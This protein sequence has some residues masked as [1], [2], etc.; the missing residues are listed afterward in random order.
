MVILI[1]TKQRIM[2]NKVVLGS[3]RISCGRFALPY[4]PEP[5]S[6]ENPRKPSTHLHMGFKGFLENK[7]LENEVAHV[8]T[9]YNLT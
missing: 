1:T 5:Q 3:G 6:L 8:Y 7:V 9:S 2:I 4:F